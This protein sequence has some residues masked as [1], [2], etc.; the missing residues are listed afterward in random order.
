MGLG[1]LKGG[2]KS[3]LA[4]FFKSKCFDRKFDILFSFKMAAFINLGDE[5][6]SNY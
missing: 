4:F 6:S 1:S 3:S 5:V 2:R